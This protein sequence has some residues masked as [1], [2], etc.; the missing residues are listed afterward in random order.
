MK[1]LID[2]LYNCTIQQFVCAVMVGACLIS[3]LKDYFKSKEQ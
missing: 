1:A 2:Y 3:M